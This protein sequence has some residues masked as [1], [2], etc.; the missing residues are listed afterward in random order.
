MT[1]ALGAQK[2]LMKEY[3][4]IQKN[5]PSS[6]TLTPESPDNLAKWSAII[7]GPDDSPYA[8]GLFRLKISIPNNY[9][10][11]PPKVIFNTKIFHPNIN[12]AGGIC[13]DILKTGERG[14]WSPALSLVQVLL[15]IQS[16]LTDPN[17][18]D[19]LDPDIAT[20]YKANIDRY[21]EIA[22]EWTRR[23]ASN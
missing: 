17:P 15:S 5:P 10:F 16:L 6:C 11:S 22:Q 1:T 3:L 8:G 19:P 20:I 9:P 4:E 21:N 2:R 18:D 7:I 13:L 14:N 12:S 23:Y